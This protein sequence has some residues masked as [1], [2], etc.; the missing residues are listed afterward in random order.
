MKLLPEDKLEWSPTVANSRMN[1]ER[2]ASGIN[3]YDQEFSFKPEDYIQKKIGE[4]HFAFWLDLCCGE[5]NAIMQTAEY[6]L[7]NS[8]Q[9]RVMLHGIDLIDSFPK[10]DDLYNFVHFEMMSVLTYN[11]DKRYDLITCVH[12]LHY[13]GDKLRAI[14]I[15][16]NLLGEGGLFIANVDLKNIII[17]NESSVLILKKAFKENNIEYNLRSKNLKKT[18]KEK[19]DFGFSFLGADD[20]YGPNY[21][22]QDSVCSYYEMK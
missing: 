21:T 20:N 4:N 22:G 1:R 3:S 15:A 8:L 6:C 13:I 18:G 2:K 10:L 19:I 11:S 5:G 14:A 16:I 12:G 9:D 7:N 17:N